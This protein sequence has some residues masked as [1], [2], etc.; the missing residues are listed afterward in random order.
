MGLAENTC[1]GRLVFL[2]RGGLARAK[3]LR[4]ARFS[5]S[6]R[7]TMTV[8]QVPIQPDLSLHITITFT[9]RLRSGGA[10]S[11]RVLFPYSDASPLCHFSRWSSK[12]SSIAAWR[13]RRGSP[14]L[15]SLMSMCRAQ[16]WP[17]SP[18]CSPHPVSIAWRGAAQAPLATM[19]LCHAWHRFTSGAE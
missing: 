17:A 11:V 6:L 1:A 16:S 19:T 15:R 5:P 2:Y 13:D 4:S 18:R 7:R 9:G 3:T 14:L 10:A 8:V 12:I